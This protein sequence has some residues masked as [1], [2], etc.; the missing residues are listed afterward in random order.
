MNKIFEM[1]KLYLVIFTCFLQQIL[2]AQ[3]AAVYPTNWWVGMKN[4]KVQLMIRGNDIAKGTA[5]VT[6]NYPGVKV[7]KVHK[8]ENDNYLFVDV[9]IAGTTKPGTAKI[10]VKK[11]GAP[12]V[13]DFVLK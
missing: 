8:V 9:A 5:D 6:I 7:Q 2:L 10:N 3:E 11:Q 1:R 13:L 12:L 4:P